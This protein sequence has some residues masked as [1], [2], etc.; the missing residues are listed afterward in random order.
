MNVKNFVKQWRE[1]NG[2]RGRFKSD[3]TADATEFQK[4]STDKPRSNVV[5]NERA[6]YQKFWLTLIRDVFDIDKPENFINFEVPVQLAHKSFIDGYFPDTNVLIEQKACGVDLEKEITQSDGTKLTPYEQA[7]RYVIGLPV[8]M[9]PKK[10]IT[11]NFKEF[12][13]YDM[14]TLKPPIKILLEELPEKFHALDFLIDKERNKIRI[15]LELSLKAG[16]IVGK[17]YNALLAQYV[18]P[19]SAESQASLNKLCVRLVFCLYAESSGI[20]G[21]HKI[22]RDWQ[23]IFVGI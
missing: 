1:V 23:E 11:C 12:L 2:E 6:D 7:R 20:F 18:N 21:K 4:I 8:S 9:H 14:E 16:E 10:I 15:E 5:A 19:N 17:L 22:F 13:I 3:G